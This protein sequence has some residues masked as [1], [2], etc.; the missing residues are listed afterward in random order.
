MCFHSFSSVI[1]ALIFLKNTGRTTL[2]GL[3]AKQTKNSCFCGPHSR[4]SKYILLG[5][6]CAVVISDLG[7]NETG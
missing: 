2:L 6:I 4:Q 5:K 3:G 7:K 1:C